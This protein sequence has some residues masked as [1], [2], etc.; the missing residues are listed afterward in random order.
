MQFFVKDIELTVFK[1]KIIKI[2][3]FGAL[4][5]VFCVNLANSNSTW[6]KGIKKTV[7][8]YCTTLIV[9]LS[10]LLS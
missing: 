8:L 7:N 4:F 1:T 6:G 9:K 10:L 5:Y 3:G 2:K